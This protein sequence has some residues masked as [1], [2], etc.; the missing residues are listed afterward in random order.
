MITDIKAQVAQVTPVVVGEGDMGYAKMT[1]LGAMFSADWRTQLLLAG[2]VY[3]ARVGTI[4][5]GADPVGVVGGGNGT[6]IDSDQPELVIGVDAGYYLI[7]IDARVAV[8]SDCDADAELTEIV[9]FA[10]RTNAPVTATEAASGTVTTPVNMLDGGAAF[11]GRCYTGCTADITDPV[12]SQILDYVTFLLQSVNTTGMVPA[13]IIRMDY[14][15]DVPTILAG[16][17]QLILCWGGTA[18]SKGI[19]I[20]TVAAVPSSY[21]PVS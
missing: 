10:D 11:P 15:P 20:V 18:A 5:A 1:K 21:F 8:Q 2:L 17:C 16:P 3:Q 14:K 7:P 6:T 4:T 9:L 13:P 12:T 19:G